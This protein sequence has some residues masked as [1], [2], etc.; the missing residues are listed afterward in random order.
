MDKKLI[1]GKA[2]ELKKLEIEK[3]VLEKK[4]QDIQSE[5]KDYLERE[6]VDELTTDKYIIRYKSIVSH[7]FD[8]TRFKSEHTDLYESYIKES[9][10]KRFTIK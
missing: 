8:T 6:G 2:D 10:S 7:K 5:I 3:K 9:V 4:I 1:D